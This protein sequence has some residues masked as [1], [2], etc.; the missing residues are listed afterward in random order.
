MLTDKQ[1]RGSKPRDREY[2]LSD[3]DRSRGNGRLVIRVRPSGTKTWEYRF[4][5]AGKRRKKTLG[6]YPEVTLASA[7][8][9][10]GEIAEGR[11]ERRTGTGGATADSPKYAATADSPKY[12][13]SLGELL[14]AYVA[15][16]RRQGKV[17]ADEIEAGFRRWIQ[18]PMPLLWETRADLVRASD[19]R[20]LLAH[21]IRRG[22]TTSTNRLRA[23]LHAAYKFGMTSENNPV[24]AADRV[25]GL[26]SNPVAAVPAQA[27][28]EKPGQRVL[29]RA[30]IR[31]AWGYLIETPG[32]GF[33][34]PRLIKLAIA[35]AGQRPSML[36]RLR[37]ADVDLER[38]VLDIPGDATK[39]GL[40][41][42][43]P[44]GSHAREIAE[45]LVVQARHNRQELLFPAGHGKGG[46][47]RLN[48][49]STAL[50]VYREHWGTEHWTMRDVRRSAKTVLGQEKVSKEHRDRL[51]GHALTDVSSK[52]YDRYD[53]LDEK[54]EAM[55]VWDAWLST[56]L[57]GNC[58]LA[59]VPKASNC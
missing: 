29:T 56:T 53:Y 5:V 19:I 10:A 54:R 14:E 55:A 33:R 20:D 40:P 59:E 43:V 9:R 15:D 48:S 22:V 52:H 24:V 50:Q 39:N 28:F 44:L 13:G 18:K 31:H 58:Q 6:S 37:L 1:I 8:Q 49:V 36:L 45:V 41:H 35:T 38:D 34:V 26:T 21:H 42:I 47:I 32:L 30:E 27:S 16:L 25:W 17:S 3:D 46:P 57:R 51:H 4:F 12:G 23:Y 2:I 11:A 7:R